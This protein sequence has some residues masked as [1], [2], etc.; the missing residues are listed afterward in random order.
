VIRPPLV[1]PGQCAGPTINHADEEDFSTVRTTICRFANCR[2][3]RRRRSLLRL[4][5]IRRLARR[6]RPP[7]LRSGQ[8]VEGPRLQGTR[9]QLPL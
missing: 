9:R 2:R 4:R 5:S 8:L 3:T 6:R 1:F 7:T